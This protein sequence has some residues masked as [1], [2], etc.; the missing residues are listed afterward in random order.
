MSDYEEDLER[1]LNAWER[2]QREIQ[3]ED[4]LE[5]LADRIGRAPDELRR[6]LYQ[7]A[8]T[9]RRLG[10][11]LTRKDLVEHAIKSHERKDRQGESDSN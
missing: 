9:L 3:T 8:A 6:D 4:R 10:T 5:E 1:F 11:A 7:L 2:V